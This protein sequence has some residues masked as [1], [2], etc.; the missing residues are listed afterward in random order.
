[1]CMLAFP[2]R[3]HLKRPMPSMPTAR[4]IT[5]TSFFSTWVMIVSK[6]VP[7]SVTHLRYDIIIIVV[8]RVTKADG[9]FQCPLV[10]CKKEYANVESFRKHSVSKHPNSSVTVGKSDIPRPIK[11]RRLTTAAFTQK[12]GCE[13][14]LRLGNEVRSTHLATGMG[15]VPVAFH[16][17]HESISDPVSMQT[18]VNSSE[19]HSA[20]LKLPFASPSV[21]SQVGCVVQLHDDEYTITPAPR[22]ASALSVSLDEALVK[23]KQ[24]V[25]QSWLPR[26]LDN[27][28]YDEVP[29]D[30]LAALNYDVQ[31]LSMP[32]PAMEFQIPYH[33]QICYMPPPAMKL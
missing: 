29:N 23:L 4:R 19:L 5:A 31:A 27:S 33:L 7:F 30:L 18:L 2:A 13:A 9:K 26:L 24:T 1:M 17:T 12:K 16:L 15:C 21:T 25:S 3:N 28:D 22:E 6:H 32:T 11:R 10:E 14:T 8:I 20:C